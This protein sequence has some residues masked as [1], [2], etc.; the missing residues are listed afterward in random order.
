MTQRFPSWS[1]ALVLSAA[2]ASQSGASS[3][4]G[5][6]GGAAE[7]GDDGG[8]A[9]GGAGSSSEIGSFGEVGSDAN[10]GGAACD[11]DPIKPP[12]LDP[13]NG[14]LAP[15]YAKYYTAYDL[16]PP[17]PPAGQGPAYFDPLGGCIVDPANPNRLYFVARSEENASSIWSVGLQ[18]DKCGHIRSFV[19]PSQ[20]VVDV[21]NADANF[22][23]RAGGGFF[24]SLYPTAQVA[25]LDSAMNLLTIHDLQ[26][27]GVAAGG[28]SPGGLALVPSGYAH[29]GELRAV[30]FPDGEWFSID[31]AK[32]SP[33][34]TFKSATDITTLANGPGGIAYV[35]AGSPGFPNP[36]VIVTE[37]IR[38]GLPFTPGQ[39]VATYEIDGDQDPIP[40]TRAD[41]FPMFYGPWGA[42][43][44]P[45][46]GDFFFLQWYVPPADH[47]VEVRGFVPPPPQ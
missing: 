33:A 43:F 47:I 32:G 2:C 41:F 34:Y 3:Q 31:I 17:P 24:L 4:D 40:S 21:P 19:G 42:Y 23:L 44:E 10:A 39:H 5:K 15:A 13:S 35:P 14:T 46:T 28:S 1:S 8:P 6:E 27:L 22:V 36:S 30:S 11:D 25:E 18:R 16:G 29:A 20:H 7:S 38:P 9:D 12:L 45:V 26:P 37:W